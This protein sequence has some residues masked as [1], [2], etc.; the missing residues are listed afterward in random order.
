MALGSCVESRTSPE[1]KCW[2]FIVALNVTNSDVYNKKPML[3]LNVA[4]GLNL[5]Q[6]VA[7]PWIY[8]R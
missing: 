3:K 5:T 6:R 4:E 7:K 1:L 8:M 2:D